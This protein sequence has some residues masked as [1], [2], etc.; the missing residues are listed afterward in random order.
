MNKN[1]IPELEIKDTFIGKITRFF[2]GRFQMALLLIVL[3]IGLGVSGALLLPKESLPEIVF[4][5]MIIQ[6]IYPGASPEDVESLVTDKIESR[7]GDLENLDEIQSDSSFGFSVVTLV[8]VEGTD[9]DKKK[10]EV[11]NELSD[12]A[13]PEGVEKS[14]TSTFSTSEIPLLQFS[15][16]G[17]YSIFTL[18][19]FAEDIKDGLE[20]VSG[21]EE[22]NIF[23][24][25]S[26]EIHVNINQ[27][28]MMEYGV[29]V[30]DIQMAISTLNVGFPVG[31]ANL[32]GQRYNLRIDE[33]V[34]T[35][36]D[37]ENIVIRT[38]RGSLVF[39]RDVADVIDTSEDVKEYNT[40]YISD[41]ESE[42]AFSSILIEVLRE[43]DSDVVGSSA[44]VQEYLDKER[45]RLYP[46]DLR[47][48]IS[49]D[50]ANDVDRDLQSIQTSAMSG[51]IVVI[52]VL[53]LFIGFKESLIV[54]ITIPMT[55]LVTLG[56]L[57]SFG[58]T[59][60]G[61]SILGL[62]VA[63][64][65]LV[66][67]SIIVMENMD[68]LNKLGADANQSA[69][70]GVNQVGFPVLAATLTTI[71]A[72][73]PLAILPGIMGAFVNSIPRT[74]IIALSASFLVAITITPA[75]YS[76]LMKKRGKGILHKV[77][78]TLK[79]DSKIM[80]VVEKVLSVLLVVLLAYYAFS[81]SETDFNLGLYAAVFFG[82]L[83]SLKI[84][85]SSGTSFEEGPVIEWYQRF[86]RSI[87][88]KRW[89][90]ILV[91]IVGFSVLVGSFGLIGSGVVKVSFFPANEP[92]SMSILVDTPGGTTL[93]ETAD[94][95][96]EVEAYVKTV[97]DIKSYN[98]T[99]GGNE[100]DK[101]VVLATFL[102]KEDMD[103]DGFTLVSEAENAL[104]KVAGA[105]VIISGSMGQGPPVGK[106]VS[107]KITGSNLDEMKNL[108]DE[109]A[110]VYST[111]PGVYNI[112]ITAKDG[113][114][115]I[116]INILER[117]AQ[118]M[119][120]SVTLIAQQLRSRV[121]GLVA[122]TLKVDREEVEVVVM[123]D[124]INFNDIHSIKAIHI[125]T[126]TG[127]MIPLTSVA[128][129]EEISGLAS[130]KH[131]DSER[132]I[133]LEAD[134]KPGFNINEVT[135]EF[136]SKSLG[137]D[138]PSGVK[139]A[140]GGDI[141]GIQESFADL[142]RSMLLAVFLV[143][144]ILSI[145][146]N[147]VAQPFAILMTVPM[148]MIGVIAGLGITGN[149]FGFYAFM[150]LV[151][152][153][154]IAVNDAIV[155]IDFMNYLRSNG[156]SLKDSIV[157][158]GAIRF[159][160]VLATTLTT[161][162]GVLPLAFRDVYYAQFSFSLV[163]GLLVTTLL[164]LIFIPVF[165]SMIEGFKMKHDNRKEQNKTAVVQSKEV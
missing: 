103:K 29:A 154:G 11:D 97:P 79:L 102:D 1:K 25:L 61:L 42:E 158:A 132:I 80:V 113:V 85:I 86:I 118:S 66:D 90:K 49:S 70:K 38:P 2:V 81:G 32:S 150:G 39:I 76:R 144:I 75:I 83:M 14:T 107:L 58:I 127:D 162:G 115:Q 136:E 64:G 56:V 55:L 78:H 139:T 22:V 151:A 148:A 121:D 114:P 16:S 26:R 54:S 4:P 153:V 164:T 92:I 142:L 149:D 117:K 63:L 67:N 52:L 59:L 41:S 129:L 19:S 31:E 57:D 123:M 17:E 60:N 88:S 71:A 10:L 155:L 105:N 27:S 94:I 122:T 51:L 33:N 65:L 146:F 24:G 145:Q 6:T 161:I 100:V 112:N 69:I 44:A 163:F 109:Y 133:T 23:G 104:R 135:R 126:P 141:E 34:T 21:V 5:A 140:Y 159:N 12:I 62:I 91:V 111:I 95:V 13:Y 40:T 130:I 37:I 106:P 99:I 128:V 138:L 120:L 84:F 74:I 68:R 137:I 89:R 147:S 18:T 160:P 131:I 93:E 48:N 82:V 110:Q 50:L 53:F 36:E 20:G 47:V 87:I 15:I 101:A 108:A 156:K 98:V 96:K 45:G 35:V 77:G 9:M 8:F 134:L 152:L 3:I 143:F 28:K 119:G 157:E 72:F 46:D 165:Y 125:Q 116:Y 73:F 43:T 124:D 30:T 7:L